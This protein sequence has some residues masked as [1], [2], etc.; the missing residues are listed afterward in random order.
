MSGFVIREREQAQFIRAAIERALGDGR[1][2]YLANL[3]R[4]T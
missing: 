3:A 1:I 4:A 2:V